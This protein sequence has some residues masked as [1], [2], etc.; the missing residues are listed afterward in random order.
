MCARACA[1]GG[2]SQTLH[3]LWNQ[4]SKKRR[5]LW[6]NTLHQSIHERQSYTGLPL[7][8]LLSMTNLADGSSGG[9]AVKH[10]AA[11]MICSPAER[12][13][14][15]SPHESVEQ[16]NGKMLRI[17]YDLTRLADTERESQSRTRTIMDQPKYQSEHP[18]NGQR[19]SEYR[20]EPCSPV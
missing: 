13:I 10:S 2:E 20:E 3:H 1:D 15:R 7:V 9:L 14:D 11:P 16:C 4:N 5:F 17:T 6:L 19:E 8:T 18:D 12:S